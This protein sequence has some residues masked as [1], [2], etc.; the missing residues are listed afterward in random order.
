MWMVALDIRMIPEEPAK[1]LPVGDVAL[2]EDA[3]PDEG[4]WTGEQGVQ[5]HRGMTRLL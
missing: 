4:P 5:D 1:E 2:V 3:V